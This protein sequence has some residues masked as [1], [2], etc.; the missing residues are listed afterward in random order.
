MR[1]SR[2]KAGLIGLLVVSTLVLLAPVNQGAWVNLFGLLVVMG[3]T[4]LAALLSRPQALVMSVVQSIPDWMKTCEAPDYQID[5]QQLLKLSQ[6]FRHGQ[7]R[8]VEKHLQSIRHPLV[9]KGYRLLLDRTDAHELQRVLQMEMARQGSLGR[10]QVKVLRSM[11]GFAPAFG[12]LGTL[13]GL[14]HML[15]GLGDQGLGY[16]GSAMGFALMT[17]LFGLLASNLLFKPLAIKLERELDQHM[18]GQYMLMEGL[19]MVQEGKHPILIR[20]RLEAYLVEDVS[21]N[22]TRSSAKA[23]AAAYAD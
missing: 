7:M 22:E 14:I 5:A 13:L 16:M 15:H 9:R 17:T 20:E 11:A 12:M 19:M 4:L 8:E 23:W 2:I 21:S 6:P 3:G 1:I 18:S 10:E